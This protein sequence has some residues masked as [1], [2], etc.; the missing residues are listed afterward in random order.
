[1]E[2]DETF[3]TFDTLEDL[4]ELPTLIS[5]LESQLSS[6]NS[7]LENDNT[8][9]ALTKNIHEIE[10]LLEQ[11]RDEICDA[12]ETLESTESEYL[13]CKETVLEKQI[14]EAQSSYL[15][16]IENINFLLDQIQKIKSKSGFR[17]SSQDTNLPPE[18]IYSNLCSELDKL[19]NFTEGFQ[20]AEIL[21]KSVHEDIYKNVSLELI[22]K[23]EN[24][25]KY[26]RVG[27]KDKI[28]SD[29]KS[30]RNSR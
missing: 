27:R 23:L 5:E 15:S 13:A 30:R 8:R 25:V 12:T 24:L 14:L 29:N 28:S 18:K 6:I 9:K 11:G 2:T 3:Y 1:M 19:P 17:R 20:K 7:K 10:E 22:A 26:P 16:A 21:V 4:D